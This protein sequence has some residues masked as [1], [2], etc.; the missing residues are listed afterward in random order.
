MANIAAKVRLGR[1]ILKS[2]IL[3]LLDPDT[4]GQKCPTKKGGKSKI[5]S[6]LYIFLGC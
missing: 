1:V 2:R 4:G 6:F 5:F 3:G